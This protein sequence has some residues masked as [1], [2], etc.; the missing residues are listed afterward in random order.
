[1]VACRHSKYERFK[2]KFCPG[3]SAFSQPIFRRRY[4]LERMGE[5]REYKCTNCNQINRIVLTPTEWMLVEAYVE[6][7]TKRQNP[8]ATSC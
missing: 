1:M 8:G 2:C 3:T 4:E 7:E 5:P 6:A